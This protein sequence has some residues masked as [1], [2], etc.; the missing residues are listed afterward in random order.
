MEVSFRTVLEAGGGNTV[1]IV[2]PEEVMTQLG[3]AK[4]YPVVVTVDGYTFRNT[5]TWYQGAFR[6]GFSAEHRTASGLSGGDEVDVTLA[7][8]NAPR[9]LELPPEFAEALAGAGVFDAF[10]ALSYSNQRGLAEPWI[11]AKS[12]ETRDRNLAKIV[13]AVRR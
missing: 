2:V 9:E 10:R 13:D 8:D 5:V 4:R 7:V 3:P 1:G 11:N 6:I 12:Q